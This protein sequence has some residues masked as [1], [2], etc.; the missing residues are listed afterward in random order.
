MVVEASRSKVCRVGQQLGIPA[1]VDVSVKSKG[2][3]EAEFLPLRGTSVFA[4][5]AIN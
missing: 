5:R 3:L 1:G 4:P 2:S